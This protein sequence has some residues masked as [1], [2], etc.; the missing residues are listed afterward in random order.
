LG[1]VATL[2]KLLH[3]LPNFNHFYTTLSEYDYIP[4]PH[5]SQ[6]IGEYMRKKIL[7][8]IF[9]VFAEGLPP[10]VGKK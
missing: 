7:V 10:H 9:Q 5:D 6:L 3:P 4:I 2:S 8:S 1:Q